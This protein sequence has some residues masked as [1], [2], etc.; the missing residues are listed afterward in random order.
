MTLDYTVNK[1]GN[2]TT[3]RVKIGRYRFVVAWIHKESGKE[4]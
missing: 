3:H 2:E 4:N 1:Y